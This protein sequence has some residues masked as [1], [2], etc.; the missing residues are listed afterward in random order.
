MTDA[1]S[2]R[3]LI[4]NATPPQIGAILGAMRGIARAGRGRSEADDKALASA[5]H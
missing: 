5:A 1:Q 3:P 4:P 2:I